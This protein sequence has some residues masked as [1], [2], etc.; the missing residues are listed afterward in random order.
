MRFPETLGFYDTRLFLQ[1]DTKTIHQGSF[2]S[3]S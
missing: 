3:L 1:P 2:F